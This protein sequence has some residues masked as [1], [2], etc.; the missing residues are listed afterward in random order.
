M[1]QWINKAKIDI[2][3]EA[4]DDY[5]MNNRDTKGTNYFNRQL[6]TCLVNKCE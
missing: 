2:D 5:E 4:L 6:W 3:E 1:I